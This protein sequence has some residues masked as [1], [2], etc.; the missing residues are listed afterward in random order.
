MAKEIYRIE[1]TEILD[2]I[3]CHTT[4]RPHMTLLDKIIYIAD[5]IEP[6][7]CE[8]P[9]LQ[10]IRRLAFADI[11]E[12][13]YTILCASLEYLK[14]KSEVIDP[15]TEQTYLYYNERRV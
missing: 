6:G 13:L 5:Y 10:E 1:N 4:G 8:A 7:R 2:A 3:S 11:D 14:S 12:C 9:D 15:L